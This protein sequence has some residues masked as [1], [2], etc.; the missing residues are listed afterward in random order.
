[1]KILVSAFS[2][3]AALTLS[4]VAKDKDTSVITQLTPIEITKTTYLGSNKRKQ[5]RIGDV[6]TAKLHLKGETLKKI[7]NL[8][9]SKQH[10]LLFVWRGSGG[11]RLKFAI[12]ESN[13][14]KIKFKLHYGRTRDMVSHRKLFV[15]DNDSLYNNIFAMKDRPKLILPPKKRQ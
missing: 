13:P 1:M 8:D 15:L 4:S 14:K 3:L 11:D 2:V 12:D 5:I 6:D 7:Q 10:A 9:F